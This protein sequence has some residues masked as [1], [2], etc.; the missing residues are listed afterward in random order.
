[1]SWME[2]LRNRLYNDD[3]MPQGVPFLVLSS[4]APGIS[5]SISEPVAIRS[6]KSSVCR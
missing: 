4:L 6:G 2:T 3:Y 1:M 5:M